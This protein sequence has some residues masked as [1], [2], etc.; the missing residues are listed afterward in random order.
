MAETIRE[1][2]LYAPVKRMLEGQGYT[3]KS[4]VGA[5]DVVACRGEEAPVIVELKTT[6]SLALVHQAIQRQALTEA[7]YVAIARGTGPAFRKALK[8]NVTLCRRLSIGLITV[9]LKDGF[10]EIHVDPAPYQPRISKPRRTRLLKEFAKR[11][12]D[13]NTGGSTRSKLMTAYRQDAL[14]CL[15]HLQINGPTKAAHVAAACAVENARRLMADDHY[16]WFERVE[17]GIYTAS[18]KGAQAMIDYAPE[19][20]QLI[21]AWDKAGQAT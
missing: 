16:G 2:D 18:P 14:R 1:T 4:E 7:V 11:V 8:N 21:K 3:V 10:T 6:F 15:H 20:A 17:T 19:L 9:R 12:G 13:P 5:A